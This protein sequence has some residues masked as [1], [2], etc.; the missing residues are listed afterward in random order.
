[1]KSSAY[2]AIRNNEKGFTLVSILISI[3][4]IAMTL[5]FTAYLIN[6]VQNTTNYEEI[7]IQ[8]FF[9]Y[10]RDDVIKATS[11][12]TSSSSLFLTLDDETTAT[13]EMYGG[14]IRRQVNNG[15]E[16]YLR[17]IKEVTFKEKP[18]GIQT[19]ITSVQGERYEKT[20]AF[21]E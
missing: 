5:P 12:T 8:Q 17:D 20:I 10:L 21:Y 16:I 11:I 15:N 19:I 6:S 4:I 18:Y 3:T 2:M 7:S 14:H 13:I 1:M 9:H